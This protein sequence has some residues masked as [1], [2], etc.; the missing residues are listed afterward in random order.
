MFPL[1]KK[2]KIYLITAAVSI[3]ASIFVLDKFGGV[4]HERSRHETLERLATIN[5]ALELFRKD[6]GR[7]PTPTEGWQLILKKYGLPQS[8]STDPWG[9][10]FSYSYAEDGAKCELYSI[11]E[12]QIDERMKGDD[13]VFRSRR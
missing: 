8:H 12:N 13:I 6:V 9:N 10:D 11:G 1:A 7:C 2:P 4:K 3:A 5:L